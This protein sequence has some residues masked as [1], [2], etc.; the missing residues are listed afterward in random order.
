LRS[1]T[2]KLNKNA[3]QQEAFSFLQ[4]S[5]F[6]EIFHPPQG[7]NEISK[8]YG[9]SWEEEHNEEVPTNESIY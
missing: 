8:F 4:N 3:A 5:K 2:S 7:K 6:K 1:R 9:L